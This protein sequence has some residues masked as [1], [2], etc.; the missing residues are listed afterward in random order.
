MEIVIAGNYGAKNL[1]DEMILEGMLEMLKNVE[2][3]AKITVLSGD[4]NETTKRHGVAAVHKFPAGIRSLFRYIFDKKAD[5]AVKNCDLFIL[6]GGGLF[7]SLTFKAN[8]IWAAQAYKAYKYKKPVIIYGQNVSPLKGIIRKMIVKKVFRS[9]SLIVVRDEK[10]KEI[11]ESL[12]LKNRIYTVPDM[13]FRKKIEKIT[14]PNR[15]KTVIVSLRYMENLSEKFKNNITKFLKKLSKNYKLK[16]IDFQHKAD[17]KLHKEI[18][19]RLKGAKIEHITDIK[20]TKELIGHFSKAKMVIG[21]RLH[22]IITAIKT[23]TPFIA[24]NYAPKV[25][26]LLEYLGLKD[27]MLEMN[28]SKFHEKFKK[29]LRT[30]KKTSEKL[31]QITE[32]AKSEHFRIEEKL[33]NYIRRHF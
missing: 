7:G 4:P 6:G 24:I 9:A 21:M 12:G 25:K 16:F 20:N 8:L 26:A 23:G 11:L 13:A 29:I 28:S 33:K 18:I 3:K 14:D 1:G 32:K 27:H 5:K 17:A 30:Y 31:K 22:S 2:P 19:K 15:S 10:S